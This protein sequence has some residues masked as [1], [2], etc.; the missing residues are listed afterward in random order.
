MAD[1]GARGAR[2]FFNK[3]GFF[4]QQVPLLF[5]ARGLLKARG[6]RFSYHRFFSFRSRRLLRRFTRS[7][8]VKSPLIKAAVKAE[9][10][11]GSSMLK[12]KSYAS[13]S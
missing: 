9:V 7:S 5:S 2:G 11:R 1:F 10:P 13:T 12:V 4:N 6:K 3:A 8:A